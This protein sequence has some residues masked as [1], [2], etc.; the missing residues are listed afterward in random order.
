MALN[1]PL[2]QTRHPQHEESSFDVATAIHSG[3][4]TLSLSTML[5]CD[6]IFISHTAPNVLLESQRLEVTLQELLDTLE[7]S[8]QQ[9][10]IVSADE[11]ETGTPVFTRYDYKWDNNQVTEVIATRVTH[12]DQADFMQMM[13]DCSTAC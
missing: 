13:F 4:L 8:P 10:M 12:P 11:G 9:S 7:T 2:Q 1:H 3:E 5:G 6:Y